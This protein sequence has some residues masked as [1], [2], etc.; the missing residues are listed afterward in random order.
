MVTGVGRTGPHPSSSTLISRT[1]TGLYQRRC[2]E[3]VQLPGRSREM[4]IRFTAR[5]VKYRSYRALSTCP[6]SFLTVTATA[7]LRMFI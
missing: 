1:V 7:Y 6:R 5:G 2:T 4:F 3:T